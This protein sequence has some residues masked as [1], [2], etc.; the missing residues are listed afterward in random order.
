[1]GAFAQLVAKGADV[2]SQVVAGRIKTLSPGIDIATDIIKEISATPQPAI[3]GLSVFR[4]H[5]D[6]VGNFALTWDE[7]D[8][9]QGQIDAMHEEYQELIEQ[10][11]NI[12]TAIAQADEST[13]QG[14]N[15][16]ALMNDAI[17][18][19]GTRLSGLFGLNGGN[20]NYDPDDMN[21]WAGQSGLN[22]SGA[23]MARGQRNPN[24]LTDQQGIQQRQAMM[25]SP[26][27]LAS[28]AKGVKVASRRS[29]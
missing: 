22:A 19:L 25:S 9:E 10:F 13:L 3:V 6:S 16:S 20:P 4:R 7:A 8:S 2:V 23:I 28:F 14:E 5:S 29:R 17:S 21:E 12:A 18:G 26:G 11:W 15:P 27:E 24:Y 1:M